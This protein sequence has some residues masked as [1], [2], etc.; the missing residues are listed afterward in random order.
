MWNFL[1]IIRRSLR[2]KTSFKDYLLHRYS[3]CNLIKGRAMAWAVS[4]LL[5][6]AAARVRSR[7]WSSGICSG[8]SGA[9]AGFLRV[10]WFAH[11]LCGLVVSV[12]GYRSKERGFDSRRYQIFWEVVGLERS[13]LSLVSITEELLEW[14]SSCSGSRKR[15]LPVVV[16]LTPWHP[17]SAKVGTNFANKWR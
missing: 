3:F 7:I 16:P 5:P 9:G 17:L 12:T 4:C 6:T 2:R 13:P 11:R 10:L 1:F 15:R 8:Q 14:K